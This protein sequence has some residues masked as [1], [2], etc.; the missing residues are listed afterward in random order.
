LTK[1]ERERRK[2]QAMVTNS[3]AVRLKTTSSVLRNWNKL[4]SSYGV[5]RKSFAGTCCINIKFVTE[6]AQ[7]F[8]NS[9]R[10]VLTRDIKN[11]IGLGRE[12]EIILA[13]MLNDGG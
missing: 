13:E 8:K 5:A 7:N 2:D 6:Q 3:L 12:K 11:H 9:R 10:D 4:H 1:N